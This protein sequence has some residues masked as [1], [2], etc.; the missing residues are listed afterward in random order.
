MRGVSIAD[1]DQ[2]HVLSFD[3]VDIL[4]AL[5]GAADESTWSLS[6]VEALG[7]GDAERLQQLSAERRTIDGKMLSALAG[8]VSQVIEGEFRAFRGTAKTPWLVI[9]AVDSSGF[10]VLSDDEDA[11][12][13]IRARFQ[14]V[15]EIPESAYGPSTAQ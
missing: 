5:G 4:A 10:D 2:R 8:N 9:Y 13:R 12:K 14:I 3:L 1:F 6:H 15:N 7:G 11:L